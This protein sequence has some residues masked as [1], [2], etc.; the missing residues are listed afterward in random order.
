MDSQG[1][2]PVS[3]ILKFFLQADGDVDVLK[4]SETNLV[5]LDELPTL[6]DA[7]SKAVEA[8]DYKLDSYSELN[9]HKFF[10]SRIL[11]CFVL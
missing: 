7:P 2:T 4:R 5:G 9:L 3:T 6:S 1:Y 10:C 11:A 8:S